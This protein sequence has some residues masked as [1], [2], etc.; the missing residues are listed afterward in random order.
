VKQ[1]NKHFKSVNTTKGTFWVKLNAQGKVSF[2]VDIKGEVFNTLD[3]AVI[4][5]QGVK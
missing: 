5:G 2:V 3:L 1:L 4:N